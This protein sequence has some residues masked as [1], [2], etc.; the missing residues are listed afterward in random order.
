M[1]FKLIAMYLKLLQ[2]YS[3]FLIIALF[4]VTISSCSQ[5]ETIKRPDVSK[6]DLTVKVERFDQ[7]FNT[8]KD[9]D[10]ILKNTEWQQEYPYFYSDYLNQMLEVGDPGDSLMLADHLSQVLKKKDF[11][12]LAHE[13]AQKF[14]NLDKQ[15]EEL[16]KAFKYIKYYFPAYK[17]PRFIAFMGGFSFQTPIGEDYIGIGLDMFLG[18]DSKFYP[19]LVRSIPL[20]MSRRFTPENITPRVVETV[21][22]EEILPQDNVNQNTLQH[23]LYNGKILYAMD[24]L[25]EGASDEV[26]IGYTAEQLAWAKKYQK[27]IWAW[28]LQEGLLYD[29]DYLKTQKYFTDAPFTPELGENN[30]SAPKLGSYIG[31]MMVRKYMESHPEIDLVALFKEKDAQKILEQSKFRGK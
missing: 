9:S 6:I 7:R 21:L 12:D 13:V 8:L 14:P 22:R 26:K 2:K 24:V 27:D 15:E 23:M 10:I 1:C 25:L 5:E 20:Y 19:A 28:F 30:E 17:M 11:I 3:F 31:W 16:T 4:H 29:T 18:A